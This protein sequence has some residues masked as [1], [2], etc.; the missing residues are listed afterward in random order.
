MRDLIEAS[1]MSSSSRKHVYH[2][3]S[4]AYVKMCLH[5]LK[6]QYTAVCGLLVGRRK[7]EK[8]RNGEGE[9]RTVVE[10]LDAMPALHMHAS[11]LAPM[12]EVAL[13]QVDE[14]ARKSGLYIVGYYHGNEDAGDDELGVAAATVA[15]KIHKNC[16]CACALL[17]RADGTAFRRSMLPQLPR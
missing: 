8:K 1:S 4:A 16:A 15:D 10:V 17:V 2:I 7:T 12:M 3:S 13:R 11:L 9:E 14:E 5:A 6:H